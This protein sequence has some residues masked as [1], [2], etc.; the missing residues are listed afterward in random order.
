M[1]GR[2]AVADAV[3]EAL[4]DTPLSMLPS[5]R[6]GVSREGRCYSGRDR[7]LEHFLSVELRRA[8]KFFAGRWEERSAGEQAVADSAVLDRAAVNEWGAPISEILE[9][10]GLLDELAAGEPAMVLGVDHAVARI[11]SELPWSEETARRVIDEF[12]L[13]GRR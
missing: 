13:R 8:E 3:R 12:A 2:G 1:V 4:D 11:S 5:G 9:L 6:L 10:F 7:Y